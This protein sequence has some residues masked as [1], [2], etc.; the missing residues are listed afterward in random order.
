[1][2]F[3]PEKNNVLFASAWDCWAFDVATF[4][5]LLGKKLDVN[6]RTLQKYMWGDYYLDPKKKK[7]LKEKFHDKAKPIF[8]QF[9]LESVWKVY[10][11]VSS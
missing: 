1:V 2:Y 7:I 4:A 11:T 10:E 8:V 3:S 6:P 9:C 5:Q